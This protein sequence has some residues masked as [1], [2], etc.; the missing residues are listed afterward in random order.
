V[1]HVGP[2]VLGVMWGAMGIGSL[3]GVVAASNLAAARYQQR[4]LVGGQLLLG[5]SMLGFALTPIYW[6]S[7]VLLFGMGLG[8]SAFNVSIQQNLQMLVPDDFRGRVLGVWSIVHSSVRPL[9]E[10]QFSAIAAIATASLSIVF[11]GAMI[12]G[13][14]LFLTFNRRPLE[15]LIR[16][17]EEMQAEAAVLGH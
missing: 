1:L 16:A 3:A 17:R 5:C 11:S 9:G 2:D 13:C 6:L 12:V 15:S 8:S 7:L 14:A 4:I 10:M